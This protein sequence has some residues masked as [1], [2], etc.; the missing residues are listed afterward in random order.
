MQVVLAFD[1]H[2]CTGFIVFW[3]GA[4]PSLC[5]LVSVC[6]FF[7]TFN[8]N[9]TGQR[10]RE[11]GNCGRE[12]PGD[13][14][15]FEVILNTANIE[16]RLGVECGHEYPFKCFVR[17]CQVYICGCDCPDPCHVWLYASDMAPYPVACVSKETKC[18][19]SGFL[20]RGTVIHM[21]SVF[22][23]KHSLRAF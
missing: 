22:V 12:E 5:W 1:E 2:H 23:G 7:S 10:C 4:H 11:G 9:G 6:L 8:L 17:C 16:G 3:E 20:V 19:S 18:S 15:V 13:A 14:S 21:D